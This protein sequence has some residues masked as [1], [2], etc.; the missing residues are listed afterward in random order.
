M[1]FGVDDCKG[2]GQ[3]FAIRV[4][5]VGDNEVQPDGLRVKRFSRGADATIHGD[6]QFYAIRF[7]RIQSIH[8]RP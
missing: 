6:D 7:E 3:V 1:L 5:M 4:M 2:G 8:I